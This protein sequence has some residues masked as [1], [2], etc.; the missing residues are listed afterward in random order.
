[1]PVYH[2]KM[3]KKRITKFIIGFLV[4]TIIVFSLLYAFG[5]VLNEIGIRL[6][7]SENDQQRNFNIMIFIWLVGASATGYCGVKLWK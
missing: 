6:Y 5:L 3:Q 4:G 2:V 1:M 7:E